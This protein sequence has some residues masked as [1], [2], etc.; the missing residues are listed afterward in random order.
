ML[1]EIQ[2]TVKNI[3][4]VQT[5]PSGFTKRMLVIT[6]EEERFPQP[7]ALSFTKE[8]CALLDGCTLGARVKVTFGIN[9]REWT[10]PSG[11]VKYFVDLTGLK[12]ENLD[13]AD[14]VDAE[15]DYVSDI[16]NMTIADDQM[17]F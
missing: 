4:E 9:G 13:A 3:G 5:F 11:N 12:V 8:R 10:D 16:S 2:G 6:T 7:V 17:P 14:A 1:Y 15:P